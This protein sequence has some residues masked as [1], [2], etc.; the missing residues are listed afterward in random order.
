MKRYLIDHCSG[1]D[2]RDIYNLDY[3]IKGREERRKL[4]ER[5]K[6]DKRRSK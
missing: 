6:H 3:F 2:N 4:L 5:R 1:E